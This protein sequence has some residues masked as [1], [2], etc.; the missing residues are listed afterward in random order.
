MPKTYVERH[1]DFAAIEADMAEIEP[2]KIT[3]AE[4]LERLTPQIQAMHR[5]GVTAE[6][7]RDVLKRHKIQASITALNQVIE[8][9]S[10]TPAPARRASAPS[11]SVM[12]FA[13]PPA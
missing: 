5:R 10:E 13:D 3:T 6:Q 1:I 11:Q 9:R 8:G 4:V 7:I 2:R 12:D